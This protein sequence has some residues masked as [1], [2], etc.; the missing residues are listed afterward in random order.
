MKETEAF[1]V[2]GSADRQILL[3]ELVR[4]DEGM[5]EE[6]LARRVAAR[7]HRTSPDSLGEEDIERAHI[8]LAHFHFPLLRDLRIIEQNEDEVC[9]TES[10]RRDQLL[11][12]AAEL[13]EW[14]YALPYSSR[15]RGSE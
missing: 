14:P 1:R 5:A 4:A 11:E 15:P 3:H 7:R 6:E 2:L 10:E 9:L 13:D 8:R 12:A